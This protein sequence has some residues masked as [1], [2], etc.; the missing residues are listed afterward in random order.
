[1]CFFNERWLLQNLQSRTLTSSSTHPCLPFQG[2]FGKWKHIDEALP[3]NDTL[4][5]VLEKSKSMGN[6]QLEPNRLN[7]TK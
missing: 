3:E 7:K 5:G 4:L 1:M 2:S 6:K